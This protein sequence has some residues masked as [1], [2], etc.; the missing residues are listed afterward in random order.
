MT[1]LV[2]K[3]AVR[4]G[5]CAVHDVV[6]ALSASVHPVTMVKNVNSAEEVIT[7]KLSIIA[8][9]NVYRWFNHL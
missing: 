6:G 8:F 7:E 3:K 1:K 4:T 2:L 9:L 5:V